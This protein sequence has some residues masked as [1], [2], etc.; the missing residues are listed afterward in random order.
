MIENEIP[1]TQPQKNT[2]IKWIILALG[3]GCAILACMSLIFALIVRNYFPQL[4]TSKSTRTNIST[5]IPN[6]KPNSLG[7]P[8]APVK[9][10]EYGDYQCPYCLRFW[11]ETESQ[12]IETYVITG[13]V[14]FEYRSVGEFLGP[15]SAA[16]AEAAY[17]A[18]DQGKYWEYHNTLFANWKGENVGNYSIDKLRNY[19]KVIGLNDEAFT[20]CIKSGAH[21][22][23]VKQDVVDSKAAGVRSTPSFVINGKLLIEGAQP[24]DI[25][26]HVIEQE[27]KGNNSFQNGDHYDGNKEPHAFNPFIAD[28]FSMWT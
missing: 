27:L 13:K 16:A 15:E 9:I 14:Y 12:L 19:A 1:E 20:T 24:F 18:G 7:D 22:A 11:E 8:N 10:I 26:Q 21:A 6:Q 23:Q 28:T 17:C 4:T 3:M 2:S 5:P 25:F